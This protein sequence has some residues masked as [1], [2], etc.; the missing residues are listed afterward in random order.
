MS[1][2]QINI[3]IAE[4]CGWKDLENEDF[5]EYGVPCFML[6]GSNNTGTR[7]APPDYCNDLNAMHDAEK[8]LIEKC[9]EGNYWFHLRE[10]LEF[11]Y[12][13]SDWDHYYYIS[14]IHATAKQRAEAFLRTIGK[15]EETK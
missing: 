6:M 3:A 14:A 11:P 13:E 8:V 1:E 10:I 4:A 7:L 2:E 12:A 5:S 15:W 9:K